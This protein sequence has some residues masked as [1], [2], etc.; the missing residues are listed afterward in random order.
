MGAA[1]IALIPFLVPEAVKLIKAVID[2]K[3][4]GASDAD[5][6][7]LTKALGESIEKLNADTLAVLAGIPEPTK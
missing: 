1:L 7:A 4:S 2:L 5:I 3:A 6:A